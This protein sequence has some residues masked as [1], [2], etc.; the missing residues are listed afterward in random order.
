[1]K[2]ITITGFGGLRKEVTGDC[3]KSELY[4]SNN[5]EVRIPI[6]G[7]LSA[8]KYIPTQCF[9]ETW[10]VGGKEINLTKFIREYG[11]NGSG[12]KQNEE[13]KCVKKTVEYTVAEIADN[14]VLESL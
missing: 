10:S 6:G 2:K 14:E 13:F 11:E 4:W 9:N 7:G 3:I 12:V 8:T 1:M 5:S